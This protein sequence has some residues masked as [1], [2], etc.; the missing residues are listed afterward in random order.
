[1]SDSWD[2]EKWNRGL[3]V[4]SCASNERTQKGEKGRKPRGLAGSRLR[5]LLTQDCWLE[6]HVNDEAVHRRF[7]Y[8]ADDQKEAL[9]IVS[10]DGEEPEGFEDAD[11][12]CQKRES[13]V[14][15]FS[16]FSDALGHHTMKLRYL[17][18]SARWSIRPWKIVIVRGGID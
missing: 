18:Y 11:V 17:L 10:V 1:M 14:G 5:T 13:Q 9:Q 6:F 15:T 16:T 3:N 4:T 8:D 12:L 7:G 2:C